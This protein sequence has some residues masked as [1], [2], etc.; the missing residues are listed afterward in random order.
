MTRLE[1]GSWCNHST[2]WSARADC[3][4]CVGM[5]GHIPESPAFQ[6]SRLEKHLLLAAQALRYRRERKGEPVADSK[7]FDTIIEALKQLQECIMGC[8]DQGTRDSTFH[9]CIELRGLVRDMKNLEAL[10][11]VD[12]TPPM[13]VTAYFNGQPV[14]VLVDTLWRKR[15]SFGIRHAIGCLKTACDPYVVNQTVKLTGF[16][17]EEGRRGV[18]M[19][20]EQVELLPLETRW[21]KGEQY[22]L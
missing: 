15:A 4:S 17:L 10:K 12:K 13:E 9:A 8:G 16:P 11:E 6:G 14:T 21:I 19:L 20:S 3:P 1:D 18:W 2:Y 5:Y 22:G 7:D